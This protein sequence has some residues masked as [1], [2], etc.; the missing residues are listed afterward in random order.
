MLAAKH[1]E[2]THLMALDRCDMKFHLCQIQLCNSDYTN[3]YMYVCESLPA[4]INVRMYVHHRMLLVEL[5]Q[6]RITRNAHLPAQQ[7][8]QSSYHQ[9]PSL[10]IR[11]F[12]KFPTPLS[13][14]ISKSH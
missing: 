7:T 10:V 13:R 12:L 1:P 8:I 3:T 9:K 4:C 6:L 14:G 5:M 2:A 11:R